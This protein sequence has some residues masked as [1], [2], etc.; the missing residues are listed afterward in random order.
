MSVADWRETFESVAFRAIRLLRLDRLLLLGAPS[1]PF[2]DYFRGFENV[3]AVKRIFG[4]KAADV[5]GK[6]KIDFIPFGGYMGVNPFN[7]HLMV[8]RRYLNGGDEL[9]VYLDLVHEL[10]HVRQFME[11]ADLFNTKYSYVERPTEVEAYRYAVEEARRLGVSDGRICEYL[12]TE[13]MSDGDLKQLAETL[14]V[15]C[16]SDV[17]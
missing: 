3:E 1:H 6:L 14:H 9:D 11:G 16:P 5:L 13:W 10:V 8:N 17:G 4:E 7:G 2:L 15:K 12:Q